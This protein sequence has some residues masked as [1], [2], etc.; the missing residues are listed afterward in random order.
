[1]KKFNNN[2]V[3]QANDLI[4]ARF[5]SHMTEQE[6][7]TLLFIIS[8]TKN[9]DVNLYMNN[10]NKIIEISASD[11]ANIM[12]TDIKRIY[13]DAEELSHNLI[14]KTLKVKYICS[15]GQYAFEEISLISRMKYESGLLTIQINSSALIYLV[16]L[17]ERFTAFRLENVIRLGSAYA[18]KLY[19]LLK[20]YE[21]IQTRTFTV[22]ELKD[23]L[24]IFENSYNLYSNFKQ[25]VLEVSKKHINL[26]TD[27]QIEYEEIKLGRK[28][29]KI[30]FHIKSK[31]TQEQ[32]AKSAFEAYVSNLSDTNQF[33]HLW[34]ITKSEDRWERFSKDLEKWIEKKIFNYEP[35]SCDLLHYIEENSL[36]YDD[37]N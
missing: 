28:V 30:K 10:Q 32:Q 25:K 23:I 19:Q 21:S 7:K 1:V 9:S 3:I 17:K 5:T 2:L 13:N 15:N 22:D 35:N 18:I 11:F 16:E 20:Q 24:A 6:Q 14:R 37:N 33:K 26:H 4:E 27:I 36:F 34:N 31:L 12:K 8:E 29:N